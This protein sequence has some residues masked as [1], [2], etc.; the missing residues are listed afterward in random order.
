MAERRDVTVHDNP[1]RSRY[2]LEFD[3]E[4]VAVADYRIRDGVM[5]LPH[6]EVA[7]EH[8]GRGLGDHLAEAALDGARAR[9]MQV[10]PSCWFIREYIDRNEQYADLLAQR[11]S[12]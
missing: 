4:L 9:G 6:T 8:R 3:G 5:V 10:V 1:D 11:R 7:A 12:A 2:E